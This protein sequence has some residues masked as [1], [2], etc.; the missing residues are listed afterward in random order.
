MVDKAIVT[1]CMVCGHP[2]GRVV[3]GRLKIFIKSRTLAVREDG[4]V[5]IRCHH[6][7]QSTDLPFFLKDSLTPGGAS[8]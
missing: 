4:G 5:E 8:N 3:N 2:L 7:K 1:E 6:C